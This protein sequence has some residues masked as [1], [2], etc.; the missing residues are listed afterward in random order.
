MK[1][2]VLTG[3]PHEHGMS[4]ELADAFC[5]GAEESGHEII[6]FDTAKMD[7]HPCKG[8]FSCHK[9]S[10]VCVQ[11]DDM[12]QILPHLLAAEVFVLVSPLYY[13]NLSSQLKTAV[14]RFFPVN[15]QLKTLPKKAILLATCGNKNEWI[16][17]GMIGSLAAMRR[18]LNLEDGGSVISFGCRDKEA[19]QEGGYTMAAENL[20]RSL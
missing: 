12:K 19:L 9:G 11:D 13:F 20:G 15:E 16:A 17:E 7:I 6:R 4:A 3:S 5:R 14:D 1:V 8:C 18:H 10:E 2:L